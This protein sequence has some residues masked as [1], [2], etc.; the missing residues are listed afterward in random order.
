[1][2]FDIKDSRIMICAETQLKPDM[3]QFAPPESFVP[4]EMHNWK[5][6]DG[7]F[8]YDPQPIIEDPPTQAERLDALEQAGLERDAALMELAM[9]L[10]GGV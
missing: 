10:T 6:V 4:E 8:V 7:E 9:M 1:M 3:V 5:V 2:Y